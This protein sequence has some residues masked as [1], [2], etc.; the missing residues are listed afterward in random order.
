[1]LEDHH[2]WVKEFVEYSNCIDYGVIH[3]YQ[4]EIIFYWNDFH[5]QDLID[6]RPKEYSFHII[7][8]TEPFDDETVLEFERVERWLTRGRLLQKEEHLKHIH[9]SG[10][11][12]GDQ[13]I[14]SINF[15]H[16]LVYNSLSC[17]ES[18]H[19]SFRFGP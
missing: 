5:N 4:R 19:Q 9:I 14:D 16:T 12:S 18:N 17:V 11:G 8:S 15:S 3:Q 6:I 13:Q 1:V 10:Y 7:R 2:E